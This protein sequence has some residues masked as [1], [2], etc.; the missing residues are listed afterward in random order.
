MKVN[1][2]A[3]LRN[4]RRVHMWGMNERCGESGDLAFID[5]PKIILGSLPVVDGHGHA[6]C[7]LTNLLR[8]D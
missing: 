3:S 8:P 2:M 6:T 1:A 7:D 5:D 4:Q